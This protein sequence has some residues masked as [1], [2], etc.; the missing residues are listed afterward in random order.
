MD[1]KEE[2]VEGEEEQEK[3]GGRERDFREIRQRNS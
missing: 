3:K 2:I 1:N